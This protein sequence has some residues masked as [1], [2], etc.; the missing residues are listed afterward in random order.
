MTK[1]ARI[2]DRCLER[3]PARYRTVLDAFLCDACSRDA[4]STDGNP[5]GGTE[6]D[7]PYQTG[8]VEPRHRLTPVRY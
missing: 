7:A 8:D 5:A 3:R 6:A 2:C 4:A 1:V